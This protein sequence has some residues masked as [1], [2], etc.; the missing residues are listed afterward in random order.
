M[1]NNK[2]DEFG[3]PIVK[4]S[5]DWPDNNEMANFAEIVDPIRKALQVALDKGDKVYKDGIEWTGLKH[6]TQSAIFDPSRTMHSVALKYCNENQSRDVFTEILSL[7]VQLGMEQGRREVKMKL[8]KISFMFTSKT[9]KN[10]LK[11]ILTY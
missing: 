4:A 7:A 5:K 8:K 3:I 10:A 1:M 9:G 6:G 11:N 2:I